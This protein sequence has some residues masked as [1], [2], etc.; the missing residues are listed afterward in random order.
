MFTVVD[1][2]KSLIHIKD[3]EI[4]QEN[5]VCSLNTEIMQKTKK[6][7]DNL[8]KP[9][10]SLGKLEEIVYRISGITGELFPKVDK[11]AIVIFCADNGVVDE[12]V[13]SCPKIVTAT[14][15]RNFTRG[16]TGVNVLSRHS[17][18]EVIVVD[19]GVDDDIFLE[20]VLNKKIRKST[21]NMAKGPAMSRKEAIK[22]IEIGIETVFELKEKGYNLLGTGEMGIGNTSTSSAVSSILANI[23]LSLMVGVGSGLS[24]QAFENKK[25]IIA[26]SIE[27][28]KPNPNDPIDVLSKVGGFDIGGIAGAYIGAAMCGIPIV[29]DGFISQAAALL[30]IK[31]EPRVKE[32]IFPSHGSAEPGSRLI[33]A[34]LGIKPY[35]NLDMR[36]GEGTGAA[37]G[38]HLIDA[39]IAAYTQ[40]GTFEDAEIKQYEPLK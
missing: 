10:G 31:I 14:V 21:S 1:Q 4:F 7:L 12:G 8:T 30:A 24:I 13:S 5:K 17:G 25:K 18:A 27:L 15:T 29:M 2:D 34:E 23:D 35:L 33:L 38:F 16:I 11:K 6:R 39:A 36:L 22:S 37:L 9:L 3:S 20:G 19:I 28:N 32:F 40:M 26:Q